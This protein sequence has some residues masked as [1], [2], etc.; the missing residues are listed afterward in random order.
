MPM[1]VALVGAVLRKGAKGLPL[2]PPRT[3]NTLGFSWW[4][5]NLGGFGATKNKP[6]GLSFNNIRF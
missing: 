4:S 6:F 1:C 2:P 3:A 5:Q